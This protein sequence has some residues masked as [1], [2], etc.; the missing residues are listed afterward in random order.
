MESKPAYMKQ[1]KCRP[2]EDNEDFETLDG[3]QFVPRNKFEVK[4]FE[5]PSLIKSKSHSEPTSD[6]DEFEII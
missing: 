1:P 3:M 5:K 2:N 4:A 6:D